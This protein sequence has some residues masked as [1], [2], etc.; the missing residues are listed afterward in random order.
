MGGCP[1]TDLEDPEADVRERGE[2]VVADILAAGLLRVAHKVALLVV[3]DGLATHRRQHDAEDDEHRQPH[4]AHEGGVL[5]DLIQQPREEAP[6]H[7]ACTARG[8]GLARGGQS[9]DTGS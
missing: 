2:G 7:G 6:A 3:V 1:G 9:E 4:L 8:R 5:G